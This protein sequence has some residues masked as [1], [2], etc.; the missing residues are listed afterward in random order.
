MSRPYRNWPNS[1]RPL[2]HNAVVLVRVRTEHILF[3]DTPLS[4]YSPAQPSPGSQSIQVFR[5]SPVCCQS[6]CCSHQHA[7]TLDAV[8]PL[9]IPSNARDTSMCVGYPRRSMTSPGGQDPDQVGAQQGSSSEKRPASVIR[10]I[11]RRIP[12]VRNRVAVSPTQRR[13][14]S[15][16]G[17]MVTLQSL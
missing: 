7:D 15:A 10:S 2:P 16:P 3:T 11:C 1:S 9:H 4:G 17:D 12:L 5:L 13:I 14:S 6:H 8:F